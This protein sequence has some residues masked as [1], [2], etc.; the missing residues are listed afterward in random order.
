MNEIRK[1]ER[2]HRH[3]LATD[4][5]FQCR[6]GRRDVP[7]A[8][9]LRQTECCVLEPSFHGNLAAALARPTLGGMVPRRNL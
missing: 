5:R 2:S 9:A 1:M 4:H 7:L 6:I 3:Q 8:L